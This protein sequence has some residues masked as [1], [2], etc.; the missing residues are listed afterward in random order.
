LLY[1]QAELLRFGT[2]NASKYWQQA[3]VQT[4][5]MQMEIFKSVSLLMENEKNA[6]NKPLFEL[7]QATMPTLANDL[8][9]MCARVPDGQALQS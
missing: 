1:V 8:F 4:L 7:F 2:Q 6:G 5:Q 3:A 9:S